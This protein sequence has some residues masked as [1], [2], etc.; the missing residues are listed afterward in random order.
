MSKEEK[1]AA[2]RCFWTLGVAASVP[3]VFLASCGG[4]FVM[5]GAMK[6]PFEIW[7]AGASVVGFLSSGA[8]GLLA[9][10]WFGTRNGGTGRKALTV[11]AF[12][13]AVLNFLLIPPVFYAVLRL[14]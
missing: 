11:T 9:S 7:L 1:T 12:V 14:F 3:F 2:P 5:D 10:L 6:S 13:L 4:L 8:L